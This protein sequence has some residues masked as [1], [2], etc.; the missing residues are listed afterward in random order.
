MNIKNNISILSLI[1]LSA[2]SLTAC[3]NNSLSSEHDSSL[4]KLTVFYD[5]NQYEVDLNENNILALNISFSISD[6]K[7]LI[8]S[9]NESGYLI[10][11]LNITFN[12]VGNY[13]FSLDATYNELKANYTFTVYV[14]DTLKLD[15]DGSINNP[16]LVNSVEDLKK[17]NEAIYEYKDL[18]NKYF[19]QTQNIS[20]GNEDWTP[21]G[22]IGIPFEGVYDGSNYE[23]TELYIDT[24][25][26]FLGVFGF[27]TGVIKNLTVRGEIYAE[28]NPDYQYA[29]SYAG[30]I[31]GAINDNALI[32]NCVSYVEIDGDAYLGGICGAIL[33]S[34]TQAVG[35]EVADIVNCK[36]YGNITADDS[37][38][39]HE[40][41]MYIGG[42]VGFCTGIITSCENYGSVTFEG[43]KVQYV[44]G[45]VGLLTMVDKYGMDPNTDFS[46]FASKN[47]INHGNVKAYQYVGGVAGANNLPLENCENRGKVEG[48]YIVA[49]V[50]GVNGTSSN[51]SNNYAKPYIKKCNNYGEVILNGNQYGAGIVSYNRYEVSECVNEGKVVGSTSSNRVAGIV[52]YLCYGNISYCENKAT[53]VG[54]KSIGGI[55][56]FQQNGNINDCT[57]IGNIEGYNTSFYVGG[58]SGYIDLGNIDNSSNEG[59]VRGCHHLGGIAGTVIQ[60]NNIISKCINM[61]DIKAISS[62]LTAENNFIGGISGMLG[63][64]NTIKQC[65]NKGNVVGYGSQTSGSWGGVGGISGSTH[66]NTSILDSDNYGNVKG[67][68][69]VG[70]IVGYSQGT[71]QSTAGYITNCR[72]MEGTIIEGNNSVGCIVGRNNFTYLSN[73]KNYGSYLG[74]T[75][76]GYIY[77]KNNSSTYDD[78]TNENLYKEATL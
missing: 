15:G 34:D 62:T 23:I 49:G 27:S 38:M 55:S 48:N 51:Y 11:G 30:G 69:N 36:N 29:H 22:T 14:Y 6:A 10:D 66:A 75:S 61:G 28:N 39:R 32:D 76:V 73:N 16:Y 13:V 3:Q 63:S 21:I 58:I 37:A 20:L 35:H 59:E 64:S 71:K 18:S 53:I 1:L 5:A 74:T 9:S 70:G 68:Y 24:M 45:V 25:N 8:T 77:G 41:A 33:R 72:N 43:N 67:Y 17:I 54:Y 40:N 78:G 7:Y 12:E 26:S 57:N 50:T 46:K 47:N 52:G 60:N 19:K 42:I 31:V 4:D 44:G 65:I 56:G 2:F